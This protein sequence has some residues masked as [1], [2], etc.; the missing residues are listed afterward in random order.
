MLAGPAGAYVWRMII[1]SLLLYGLHWLRYIGTDE[2]VLDKLTDET[3][4]ALAG[5][6]PGSPLHRCARLA[7]RPVNP[8]KPR[9]SREVRSA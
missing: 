5:E 9:T 2:F 4:R 6:R 7:Q 1:V 8:L 3:E